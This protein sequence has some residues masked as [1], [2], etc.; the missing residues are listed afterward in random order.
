MHCS[1]KWISLLTI[2]RKAGKLVMGFDP[3]KEEI[4][5][6]RVKGI[7]LTCDISPKTKKEVLFHSD[8]AGIFVQETGFTMDDIAAA[9]GRRAGVLAVC[10]EGLAAKLRE[11]SQ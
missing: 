3:A 7:F 4:K 5:G 11:L 10:D 6:G 2:C 8:Q 1:E 9:V